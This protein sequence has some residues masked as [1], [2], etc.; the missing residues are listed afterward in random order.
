MQSYCERLIDRFGVLWGRQKVVAQFGT[1]KAEIDDTK[2]AWEN[3]LRS[4][5]PDTIQRVLRHL[6]SD[7]PA[8]PPSLAEWI[9]LC[10]QFNAVEH[11]IALPPPPKQVTDEGKQLIAEAMTNMMQTGDPLAWAKYPGSEL[12]VQFI[13]RG[14]RE[15][16]RLRDILD[17]HLSTDG[18][19]C[20][21]EDARK[22]IRSL[23]ASMRSQLAVA[24]D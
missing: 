20:R 17:H 12:A 10:K 16:R 13:A 3:Q 9:S 1:T 23:Q 4:V 21:R 19:D 2:A 22:A 14:A 15:D 11:R 6:Q 7:P 8:W 18:R 24:Q 5:S